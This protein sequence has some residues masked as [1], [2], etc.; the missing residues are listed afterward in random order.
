MFG[1]E[2]YL[3]SDYKRRLIHA[4]VRDGDDMNYSRFSGEGIRW[5]EILELAET[6]PFLAEHRVIL[7]EDSG[8]FS[9]TYEKLPEFTDYIPDIPDA[10]VIIF[11]E[12]NVDKRSKL[13]KNVDKNGYACE[14]KRQRQG[15]IQKWVE[16]KLKKEGKN[17]TRSAM[18][19][20]FD[21]LGSDMGVIANELEKLIC[22]CMYKDVIE[23]SD[24][25]NIC[26]R[27]LE[28]RVFDMV[29][30]IS[31][32]KLQEAMELYMELFSLNVPSEKIMALLMRHYHIL[33]GMKSLERSGVPVSEYASK[34]QIPP[35]TV[36]KYMSQTA[37]LSID[38]IRQIEERAAELTHNVRMGLLDR[39]FAVELLIYFAGEEGQ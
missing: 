17:I 29:D 23:L 5:Q 18:T 34:L 10:T 13:Y 6:M 20:F 24:V 38:R 36:K 8:F 32:F 3:V 15:D 1:E 25:K 2:S 33:L 26:G 21:R 19:E 28:D 35:F 11:S 16:D 22:Y 9:M 14:I 31:A 39:R 30:Y 37:R 7:V 4:L 12:E 27:S